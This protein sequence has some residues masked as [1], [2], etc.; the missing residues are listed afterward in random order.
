MLRIEDILVL[1][2]W[3][4]E[5]AGCVLSVKVDSVVVA[6]ARVVAVGWLHLA[7]AEVVHLHSHS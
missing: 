1:L 2:W 6:D 7:S 3:E 5:H 4:T